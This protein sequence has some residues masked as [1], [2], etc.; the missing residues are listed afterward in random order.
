MERRWHG[1]LEKPAPSKAS[2]VLFPLDAAAYSC[3]DRDPLNADELQVGRLRTFYCKTK[4][5]GFANLDHEFVERGAIGVTTWQL[6]YRG[7]VQALFIPLNN[8]IKLAHHAPT[9]AA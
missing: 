4:L 1:R 9:L 5:N 7:D 2:P 6:R 8:D 3:R